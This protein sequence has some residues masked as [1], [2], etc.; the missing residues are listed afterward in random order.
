M[1]NNNNNDIYFI[2]T[3]DVSCNALHDGRPVFMGS[4]TFRK[5]ASL[6]NE[7]V[8]ALSKLEESLEEAAVAYWHM[9][10]PNAQAPAMPEL[11]FN[12]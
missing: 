10:P 11:K 6:S 9:A 7:D 4:V 1:S 2:S 8:E 3:Y 5:A 12:E